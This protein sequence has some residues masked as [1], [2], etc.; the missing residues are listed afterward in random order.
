MKET[1]TKL[2]TGV[3]PAKQEKP[4]RSKETGDLHE[5]TGAAAG[6]AKRPEGA[7][8]SNVIPF[9]KDAGAE[10]GESLV[11][12]WDI[13]SVSRED[14]DGVRIIMVSSGFGKKHAA[15]RFGSGVQCIAA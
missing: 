10:T 6:A 14:E 1:E 5:Q 12:V 15:E 4:E 9:R 2:L 8:K 3:T 7:G 11:T 13:P